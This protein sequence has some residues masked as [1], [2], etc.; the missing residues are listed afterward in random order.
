MPTVVI[1]KVVQTCNFTKSEVEK[2]WEVAKEIAKD[3]E[4]DTK[5]DRYYQI[6]M[7]VFKKALGKECTDK[8]GWK[9]EQIVPAMSAILGYRL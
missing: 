1:A 4:S 3:Y 7:G 5:S 2:K 9:T 8:L 6:T